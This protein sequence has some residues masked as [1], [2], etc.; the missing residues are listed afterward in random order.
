MRG[1]AKAFQAHSQ[2]EGIDLLT[3]EELEKLFVLLENTHGSKKADRSKSS[4]LAW[5]EVLRPWTY[6]Q[7]RE[8]AFRRARE[9]PY[10][11]SAAEIA[12]YCP[13][14][15]DEYN[16]RNRPLAGLDLARWQKQLEWSER[17]RDMKRRRREAGLP[18]T[19]WAAKEAGMSV[20]EYDR[21][22]EEAGLGFEGVL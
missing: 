10:F 17:Y 14:V 16:R 20:E 3:N 22:V 12:A 19:A 11:P 9:N 18:E 15:P 1:E 21:M 7:V 13:P 6:D 4:R 8:A 5:L 2:T